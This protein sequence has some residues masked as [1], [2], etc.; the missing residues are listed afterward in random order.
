MVS[1]DVK[2]QVYL[3]MARFTVICFPFWIRLFPPVTVHF[4]QAIL[5]DVI[6]GYTIPAGTKIGISS[7]ALHRYGRILQQ[8]KTFS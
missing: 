2:H 5:D 6:Q 7:G 4:R 8:I 3:G 1:V